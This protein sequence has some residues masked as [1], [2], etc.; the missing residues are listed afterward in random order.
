MQLEGE[1]LLSILKASC[2]AAV[3]V[4]NAEGRLLGSVP[5]KIALE[6]ATSGQY[7][8]VGNRRRIRY[9]RPLTRVYSL[10]RGSQTT[11]RMRDRSGQTMGG[12]WVR[13]HRALPR[14][15]GDVR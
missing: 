5:L 8:G 11:V 12:P 1:R 10:N 15:T 9:L 4:H 6:L 2:G 14:E 13:E 3:D 7:V